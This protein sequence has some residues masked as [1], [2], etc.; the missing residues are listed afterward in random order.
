MDYRRLNIIWA[1]VTKP[2][3]R[4][5]IWDIHIDRI[6][7]W[8]ICKIFGAVFLCLAIH[9][10]HLSGSGAALEMPFAHF[11]RSDVDAVQDSGLGACSSDQAV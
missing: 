7:F 1:V 9:G 8:Y 3:C 6:V 4:K 5:C 2:E 10:R 11:Y